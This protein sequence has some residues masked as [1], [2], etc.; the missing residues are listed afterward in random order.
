MTFRAVIVGLIGALL[1]SGFG[2]FNDWVL[3]LEN[4]TAG[5][6]LPVSVLGLLILAMIAVNPLLRLVRTNWAFRAGEVGV[7]AMLTM[8]ACS[9]PGRGLM[10]QFTS[11]LAMPAYWNQQD[12]GMRKNRVLEYVP[13]FMLPAGGQYD[14]QVVGPLVRG[15][16]GRPG[17]PVGFDRVPWNA[18]TTPMAAW[19]PLLFLS[20]AASICLGLIVHRQWSVHERLQYPIAEFT[21]SLV[22][23]G[24]HA[25]GQGAGSLF[26]SRL[27]WIGLGV[28]LAIRV[29][30]G[31]WVWYPDRMIQIPLTF[32]FGPVGQKWPRIARTFTIMF[33]QWPQ[34]C[35][36]AIAFC[37]FLSSEIS[38][39]L[40]LS[41]LMYAPVALILIERGVDVS[42]D[43]EIGGIE[44]WQR[45]GS[46]VAMGLVLLYIGRRY[47]WDVLRRAVWPVGR[48]GDAA[49]P[50]AD[51]SVAWAARIFLL[52]VIAMIVAVTLMGLDWPVAALTILLMLLTFVCVSRIS[53]ETGLFFVQPGWQPFGFLLALFGPL[54]IGPQ[55]VIISAMVCNVLCVDQ[56]MAVMPYF[57]NGLKVCGDLRVQPARA[58]WSAMGIY[59]AGVCLAVPLVLWANY[60]YGFSTRS[61]YSWYWYRRIP[62]VP[63]RAAEPMINTLKASNRL[64]ESQDL[65]PLQRLANIQ[66]APHFLAAAGAGFAAVLVFMF[67]RLRFTWWPLHPVMFLVWTTWP[68]QMFGAS[69]LLGW[70]LK[71]AVT[72]LGGTR[73]HNRCKPLMI[74]MVAGELLGAL[75]FMV[76]GAIYYAVT[77]MLPKEYRIFPR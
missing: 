35:P 71:V 61:G 27:F 46:Y 67:L 17:Q 37:F 38:L 68:I 18:W 32:D 50:G 45:A 21:R 29:M 76:H 6:Q 74:G 64:E 13:P 24:T 48:A 36:V 2:Y 44:G 3:G 20:A 15:G 63:F 56:S 47:Y 65:S 26:R 60:N 43:Y 55:G 54:A 52:S 23:G 42:T 77:D 59:V 4:V 8:V 41:L 19:L 12:P 72:R 5:H 49:R 58:G 70:A 75:T 53:A 57:V 30:N 25:P 51:G 7:A 1:I 28:V 22:E 10:E 66:P 14:D 33:L 39:T 73:L 9:V 16:L 62:T 34:I 11:S 31:I 69:F 40:G